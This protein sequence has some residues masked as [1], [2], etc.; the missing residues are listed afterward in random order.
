MKKF[1]SLL[2]LFGL[3]LVVAS[4]GETQVSNSDNVNSNVTSNSEF[5]SDSNVNSDINSED[6]LDAYYQ[7]PDWPEEQYKC[8]VG[9]DNL[10][11]RRSLVT[12]ID[13]NLQ[14]SFKDYRPNPGQE[15]YISSNPEVLTID[16]DNEGQVIIKTLHA[17][18]AKVRILDGDGD[19]R[20]CE[21]IRVADPIELKDMED[22]LVYNCN[23]WLSMM[24]N[25][26]EYTITFFPGNEYTIV[27]KD[28]YGSSF[29]IVNGTYE[30]VETRDALGITAYIYKFTDENAALL[31]LE[32]FDV[33]ITGEF[34]HLIGSEITVNLLYPDFRA[35]D[36]SDLSNGY[37][38]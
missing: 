10:G 25:T 2:L 12:G 33:D 14:F 17:G 13:Y 37:Y 21:T 30:Y 27:G 9:L 8:S 15:Q 26:D 24:K 11:V 22:H 3:S 31:Q 35:E 29:S 7:V 38:Y 1:N 19:I 18:K 20:Y 5:N 34:M 32:G 23:E 16:V 4:C 36:F 28:Q 6:N